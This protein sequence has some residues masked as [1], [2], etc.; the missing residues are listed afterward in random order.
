MKEEIK[1]LLELGTWEYVD[2]CDVPRDR[3]VTKSKWCYTIKYHRDGSIERFK[4]RFVVCGYSQVQGKDN[5]AAI[6]VAE[7]LGVTGR[8]KHF[9]DSLH[10]FRHLVDHQIVVP[11]F[12]TTKH[13]RADG[14]TKALGPTE[15][16]TWRVNVVKLPE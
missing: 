9:T 2:A 4:A 14:Y 8:N 12:V 1:S 7:N 6:Q 15:F 5:Q 10:Y 11:T 13:Q 3:N 16:K